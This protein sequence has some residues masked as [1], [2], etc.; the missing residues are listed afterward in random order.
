MIFNTDILDD[1]K[2]RIGSVT[3]YDSLQ[4]KEMS[5]KDT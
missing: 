1:I 2:V 5:T 3:E 4:K